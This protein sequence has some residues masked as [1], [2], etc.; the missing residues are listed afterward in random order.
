ML[1]YIILM[2]KIVSLELGYRHA[3]H[4]KAVSKIHFLV[5]IKRNDCISFQQV[6][7]A[8]NRFGLAVLEFRVVTLCRK[9]RIRH[10]TACQ[11]RIS[12]GQCSAGSTIHTQ[13]TFGRSL[14]IKNIW[15]AVISRFNHSHIKNLYKELVYDQCS[16]GS[17][18][19]TQRAF[20]KSL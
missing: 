8:H 13:R 6:L 5:M 20:V 14:L 2:A 17:T 4:P 18:I 19:H 1:L 7:I 10:L 16:A 12:G 3:F 15:W 9:W 11:S